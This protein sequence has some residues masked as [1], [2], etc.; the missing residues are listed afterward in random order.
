MQVEVMLPKYVEAILSGN[1]STAR[2]IIRRLISTGVK[3]HDIYRYIFFPSME[4]ISEFYREDRISVLVRNMATRINR[5]LTDQ[6]QAQLMPKP[7]NGKSAI[8]LCAET[9]SEELGGQMCADL[10]ESDGWQVFFLGSGVAE[11]DVTEFIGNVNPNLLVVYGSTPSGVPQT[12]ELIFRIR[13]IGLCPHMNVLLTGGIFN[14]VEG[15]WEELRADLYASNPIEMLSLA[16][17]NN[18][19]FFEPHDPTAPKRRRRLVAGPIN[20]N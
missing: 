2:D 9:E 19:R 5:F 15:L 3:A 1:R 4:Q 8:I 7:S 6:V 17:G 13:E 18:R 11:D 16:N 10:L 14:R 20:M 12:R